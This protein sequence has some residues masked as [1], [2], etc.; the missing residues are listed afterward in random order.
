M[1]TRIDRVVLAVPDRAPVALAW[2]ELLGAEIDKEDTIDGLGA[3]RTQLRLGTG[4]VD[5]LEPDGAG[6]VREAVGR[7]GGHVF[8]AGAATSDTRD[9]ILALTQRRVGHL[10]LGTIVDGETW[11]DAGHGLRLVVDLDRT[12][13][14]VGRIDEFYEVTNLVD[15]AEAAARELADLMGLHPSA[16]EP[17]ASTEY[18]YAGSLTL[19]DPDRLHRVEVIHPDDAAKTMGRYYAKH[20][21]SLYMCFAETGELAGITA[22]LQERG[23]PHTPVGDH[24]TFIHPQALG[25][26]MVGLSRRTYAWTW[27]G[28]PE[29][30][31]TLP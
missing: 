5:L 6:P 1:L 16:F 31:E 30:V 25:G 29:R 14:A 19:F 17:I 8:A 11:F 20:G 2:S 15:D 23:V 21:E 13:P 4:R 26:A 18:G 9:V 24:T 12:L 7:R 22:S 28:H 3:R 10:A 27:S